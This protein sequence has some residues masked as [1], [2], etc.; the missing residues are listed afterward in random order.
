M[1]TP[2]RSTKYA[3]ILAYNRQRAYCVLASKSQDNISLSYNLPN[4]DCLQTDCDFLA[5]SISAA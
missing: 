5:M 1:L 3:V 4:A 2:E